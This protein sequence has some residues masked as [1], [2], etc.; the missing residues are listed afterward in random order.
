VAQVVPDGAPGPR[1]KAGRAELAAGSH[2]AS[3]DRA[4]AIAGSGDAVRPAVLETGGVEIWSGWLAG[5]S[6]G[7][8]SVVLDVRGGAIVR[9]GPLSPDD[10]VWQRAPCRLDG[11]IGSAVDDLPDGTLVAELVLRSRP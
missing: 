1:A 10:E 4:A 11:L 2:E 3:G 8:R 7:R 6:P 9:A 5:C